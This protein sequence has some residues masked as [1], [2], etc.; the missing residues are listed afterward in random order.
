MS[1]QPSA[2]RQVPEVPPRDPR[3]AI[4]GFAHE[5][6]IDLWQADG[7]P[8]YHECLFRIAAAESLVLQA[9][10]I[11]PSLTESGCLALLDH[12]VVQLAFDQLDAGLDLTL[13]C[14]LSRETLGNDAHWARLLRLVR[15]NK[16]QARRLV[17]E[18]S[19]ACPLHHMPDAALKLRSLQ[20]LGCRIALD[21]FGSGYAQPHF[22]TGLDLRWDIIKIDRSLLRASGPLDLGHKIYQA[23]HQARYFAASVVV[24]GIETRSDM[25]VALSAGASHGQGWLWKA[26]SGLVWSKKSSYG[27]KKIIAAVFRSGAIVGRH[28]DVELAGKLHPLLI[29]RVSDAGASFLASRLGRLEP[30]G[31]R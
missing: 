5:P 27:A 4:W 23:V 31:R 30:G 12:L 25:A 26:Q 17:F 3:K 9:D 2:G 21:D 18:I 11:L 10:A 6:I 7:P 29:S 24:E 15:R 14:N 13:G 19:E 8:L 20:R 1:A 16:R 22:I 28:G